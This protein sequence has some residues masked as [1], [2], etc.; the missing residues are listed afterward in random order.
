MVPLLDEAKETLKLKPDKL[1]RLKPG[2]IYYFPDSRLE[3]ECREEAVKCY[4]EASV[5]HMKEFPGILEKIGFS[6][7]LD[8]RHKWHL[9]CT[10]SYLES[11]RRPSAKQL[12]M[13]CHTALR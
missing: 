8:I 5:K 11:S 1:V 4:M 6:F 12:S 2:D 7:I 13:F 9:S 10:L 3:K